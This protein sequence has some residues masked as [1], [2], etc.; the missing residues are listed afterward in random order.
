MVYCHVKFREPN[1][2][3]GLLHP[4]RRPTTIVFMMMSCKAADYQYFRGCGAHHCTYEAVLKVP[5]IKWNERLVHWWL[6]ATPLLT[7][8][9]FAT[10]LTRKVKRK[11]QLT[12]ILK[13]AR[14]VLRSVMFVRHLIG[15]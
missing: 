14:S 11:K 7:D 15:T 5:I 1:H 12:Q 8:L 10:T 9:S 2:L 6:H 4:F 3:H 13:G